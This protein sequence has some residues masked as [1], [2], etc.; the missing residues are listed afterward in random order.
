MEQPN[1]NPRRKAIAL[2][3]GGLDSSL[4]AK[5]VAEL[6]VEVIGLHLTSPFACREKVQEMAD[7]LGIALIVKDKGEAYLDLIQNPR[8][9]YGRSMNPCIDCRIFMFQLADVVRLENN[10]D[11]IISG[12][13]IGQRPM[14]QIRKNMTKIDADAKMNDLVLRPLSAHSFAPTVPEREGWVAREKLFKITGRGRTQQLA[15]A[16]RYGIEDFPSPG[17]GCLL[18]ESSFGGKVKDFFSHDSAPGTRGRMEHAAL[19]RV[20]RHFR[21]SPEQKVIVGRHHE[22]N[23]AIEAAWKSIGGNLM[24]PHNFDGPAAL[25]LGNMDDAFQEIVGRMLVRYSGKKFSESEPRVRMQNTEGESFF[26]AGSAIEEEQLGK[27][28]L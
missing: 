6:G 26:I 28:R 14:S 25:A 1:Y 27:Y 22:D 8:H 20:G 2:M 15:L 24:M 19:L 13:V 12:E 9:G 3:S 18:T 7:K 23:Q 4:A 11:F 10:A 16:K 17:G 21:V 5:V